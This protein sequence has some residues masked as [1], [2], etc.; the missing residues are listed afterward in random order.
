MTRA[1]HTND[2]H[3]LLNE[4]VLTIGTLGFSWCLTFLLKASLKNVSSYLSP[5][6]PCTGRGQADKINIG[7]RVQGIALC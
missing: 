7:Y 6:V 4:C 1:A 2:R 5:S 3:R